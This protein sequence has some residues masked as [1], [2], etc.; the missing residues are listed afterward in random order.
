MCYKRHPKVI[1]GR[2]FLV[3]SHLLSKSSRDHLTADLLNTFLKL[4]KYL[5]TC[6]TN[7][8]LA[9]TE[10]CKS[11]FDTA[12]LIL[13]WSILDRNHLIVALL[14][15]LL[16]DLLLKQLLDHCL[17]NPSLW[18][19]TPA[20][21]REHF[22]SVFVFFCLS[23]PGSTLLPRWTFPLF[24]FCLKLNPHQVQIRLYNYLSTDFLADTQVESLQNLFRI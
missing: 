15:F 10:S 17:F 16:S 4:T 21:V 24:K 22:V 23:L 1:A 9:L 20:Q 19:H 5:V 6:P 2:G 12:W 8:R 14:D 7:N 11:C 18:I 3:I 13:T